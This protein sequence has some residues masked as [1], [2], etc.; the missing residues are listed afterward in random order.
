MLNVLI[1]RFILGNTVFASLAINFAPR[2][3]SSRVTKNA[4]ILLFSCTR[5]PRVF[6]NM[7]EQNKPGHVDLPLRAAGTGRHN[8]NPSLFAGFVDTHRVVF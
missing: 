4:I 7:L 2:T 1:Y 6:I 8:L 5:R 3:I